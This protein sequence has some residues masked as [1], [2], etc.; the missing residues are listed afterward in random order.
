MTGYKFRH[1]SNFSKTRSVISISTTGRSWCLI[2]TLTTKEY[3][4][5]LCS[6][7]KFI[8]CIR[9]S[10]TNTYRRCYWKWETCSYRPIRSIVFFRIRFI[11]ITIPTFWRSC[12]CITTDIN[13]SILCSSKTTHSPSYNHST[14]GTP[15]TTNSYFRGIYCASK[16][17]STCKTSTYLRCQ[18]FRASYQSWLSR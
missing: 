6:S 5:I 8:S 3:G 9:T 4:S 17:K 10:W 13:S 7:C 2:M 15:C 12:I 1:R 11:S 16:I 14:T 18:L